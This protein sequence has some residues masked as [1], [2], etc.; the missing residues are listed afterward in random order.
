[1]FDKENSETHEIIVKKFNKLKYALYNTEISI[2]SS[3]F[4]RLSNVTE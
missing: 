2:K 3:R 1:V 4:E